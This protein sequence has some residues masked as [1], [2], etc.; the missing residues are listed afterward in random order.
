MK[1]YIHSLMAV[2]AFFC[3]VPALAEPF[4]EFLQ[5]PD[6]TVRDRVIPYRSTP[7]ILTSSNLDA[8]VVR[9]VENGY[10]VLGFSSF[11]GAHQRLERA[12]RQGRRLRAEVVIYSS[13]YIDTESRGSV[14]MPHPFG[15]PGAVVTPMEFSRYD[16]TAVYLARLRPE[17]IGFGFGMSPL[18]PGQALTLGSGRGFV[19]A[20]V[21]R[22]SPAFDAGIIRGD[23]VLTIAGRD[24]STP[25]R[26]LEVRRDLAG[27]TADVEIL[28]G[29]EPRTHHLT[30]PAA[31]TNQD[32]RR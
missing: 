18:T 20:H 22:G 3:A 28:R 10:A 8:D 31:P 14:I 27:Q 24:V 29:G 7:Q 19:V 17:Q 21:V 15:I 32:G 2:V 25:E 16:Q 1:R 23:I 11:I 4:E 6:A 12:Q 13:T 26:L 9:F 5:Q 30:V